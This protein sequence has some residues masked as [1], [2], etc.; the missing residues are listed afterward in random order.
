[1]KLK[2]LGLALM[3][4]I[5]FAMAATAWAGISYYRVDGTREHANSVSY[6]GFLLTSAELNSKRLDSCE[7]APPRDLVAQARC[8]V[9]RENTRK[10]NGAIGLMDPQLRRAA[11]N[12]NSRRDLQLM[13]R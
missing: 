3:T 2:P 11:E 5:A 9:V 6:A 4:A 1:M 8:A 7:S 10:L 12:E 13:A